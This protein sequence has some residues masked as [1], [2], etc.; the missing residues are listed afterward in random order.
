MRL[1]WVDAFFD[2]IEHSNFDGQNRISLDRITQI[3]HPFGLTIFEGKSFWYKQ[4]L[5]YKVSVQ[6][7]LFE[8]KLLKREFISLSVTSTLVCCS[9]FN[10]AQVKRAKLAKITR[11]WWKINNWGYVLL[12]LFFEGYAYYTDWRLGGIVRVRKTDGGEMVIIRRGISHIMHVK[13]F[14]SHSQI[15]Q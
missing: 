4:W 10:D 5:A 1:Y 13:S 12:L 9:C 8:L 14:S 6:D 3:S 7:N 2:K 11:R 15:G